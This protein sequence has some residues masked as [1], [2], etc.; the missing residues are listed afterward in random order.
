MIFKLDNATLA[1]MRQR[2]ESLKHVGD[3][4]PYVRAWVREGKLKREM[5]HVDPSEVYSH[6]P[7]WNGGQT[8]WLGRWTPRTDYMELENLTDIQGD[9]GFDSNGVQSLT[10]TFD[11]IGTVPHNGVAG[12]YHTFERG[13]FSPFLGYKPPG[14]PSVGEKNEWFDVLNDR[15][16][17]LVIV[18]GYGEDAAVPIFKGL[19]DQVQLNSRP[20][21]IS[22]TA[23]DMGVFLTDQ[24]VFLNAKV[25]GIRDPITFADRRKAFEQEEVTGNVSASGQSEGHPVSLATDENLNSEWWSEGHDNA[26]PG[27]LPYI[28]M[29]LP[30]GV[31]ESF[32]I[33]P[34]TDG[35]EVFVSVLAKDANAPGGA[36]AKRNYAEK[37][38]DGEWINEG[39]GH[40]PG[41]TIPII[42][43]IDQLKAKPK[44]VNFP[45]YGY[46]LGDGSKLRVYFRGLSQLYANKQKRYRAAVA[47]FAAIKQKLPDEVKAAK[48]ILV[49]DV[50]D[51]VRT[52][53]QWCGLTDWEIENTGV[54]LADKIVF[55]RGDFLID[56]IKHIADLTN[57]VF[58]MKPPEEFDSGDLGIGNKRN[59]SMGVAVFRNNQAMRAANQTLDPI[60]TVAENTTLQGIEPVFSNAPL[61]YNIRVRG[62]FLKKKAGGRQL[63]GDLAHEI[64]Y[65]YQPP[66]SR[67]TAWPDGTV[68]GDFQNANLKQYVVH[69]SH[70]L[71]TQEKCKV[72]ALFIAYREALEAFKAT[73][74]FPFMPSIGLDH[75]L[76]VRDTSTG[77]ST[78]LWIVTRSYNIHLGEEPNFKT[79]VGGSC[80]DAPDIVLVRDELVQ[81]LR[82]HGYDP[83]LSRW[84]LKHYGSVYANS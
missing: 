56:I 3:A 26:D 2:W 64:M 81:S 60:E 7:N 19:I 83:G 77:L 14:R 1:R 76:A 9:Q 75:Q 27:N 10:L 38:P 58:Y 84:E 82:D 43:H 55:N 39:R 66:W 69:H 24:H 46:I 13:H 50:A 41:T 29:I 59:L 63:G 34:G 65:V 52:V 6:I 40:V 54:R 31:Y 5:V 47:D 33:T 30:A 73:T 74:E 16:T 44:E 79:A 78:R 18:A 21:T 4:R 71:D 72:A 61:A 37:L 53:L 15:S 28:E 49:D 23:R 12:L 45:E 57:F 32:N 51:I 68:T 36:G 11:N 8:I 25:R 22:L 67:G 35:M 48:W 70:L 20:D 80:I 42:T 17:E 62:K